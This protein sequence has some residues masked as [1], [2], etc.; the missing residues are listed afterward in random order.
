ML[1]SVS[2]AALVEVHRHD[3]QD[4]RDDED[5][6]QRHVHGVPGGEQPLIDQGRLPC[7]SRAS[8]LR[9]KETPENPA[10]R[11]QQH[12]EKC[13]VAVGRAEAKATVHENQDGCSGAQEDVPLKPGRHAAEKA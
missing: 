10:S 11:D 12:C 1:C 9:V 6:K 5:Q 3:M 8:Q 2:E 13:D 4:G 7:G